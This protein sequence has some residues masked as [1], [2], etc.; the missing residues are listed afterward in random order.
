MAAMSSYVKYGCNVQ[1]CEIWLQCP[2]ILLTLKRCSFVEWSFVEWSFVE[3]S[4]VE[5]SFVEWSFVEWSFVEWSF[6]EWS[7]V[8]WS[9]VEWSFVEWS[10]V[11]VLSQSSWLQ[12]DIS[13]MVCV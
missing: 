6:V 1:L 4:F 12:P 11:V 10:F 3:W 8:E 2:A 13:G 9:F 7:F 5:W